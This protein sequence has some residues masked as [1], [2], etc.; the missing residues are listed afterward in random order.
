VPRI[1]VAADDL[2]GW[3]MPAP[4]MAV[5]LG[6]LSDAVY[7]KSNLPLRVREI[8]RY[9]IALNTGCEVCR[10]A[11]DAFGPADGID[12]AF[13]AN[14][15]DWRTYD[16]YSER[17]KLAAEFAERFASGHIDLADDDDFFARLHAAYGESE[18]VELGVSLALWL[19]SGRLMK[20]LD[21]GQTCQLVFNEDKVAT[22]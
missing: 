15:P 6:G 2:V 10:N 7:N 18:I 8:A 21:V 16:G 1:D 14:A 5:A 3:L 17:E 13:Y 9:T 19:G 4:D 12:D 20:V 11:R 22:G